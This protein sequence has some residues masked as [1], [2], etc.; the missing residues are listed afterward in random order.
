MGAVKLAKAGGKGVQLARALMTQGGLGAA[1]G[2]SKPVVEG[3]SRAVN[4]LAEGALGAAGAAPV[5]LGKAALQLAMKGKTG[6]ILSN[7]GN[8]LT[9]GED[10]KVSALKAV[11]DKIGPQIG[12]ITKSHSYKAGTLGRHL[13]QSTDLPPSI[14]AKIKALTNARSRTPVAGGKVQDLREDIGEMER[15][16][17][18]RIRLGNGTVDDAAAFKALQRARRG[19]DDGVEANVGGAQSAALRALHKQYRTGIEVPVMLRPRQQD[20]QDLKQAAL[21]VAGMEYGEYLAD[22]GPQY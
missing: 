4:A 13:Q 7:L 6:A 8:K 17:A 3:E 12:E 16:L 18:Q 15:T 11:Q 20:I 14:N 5:Q 21:P 9:G 1:H 19:L 22:E 2:A 10:A